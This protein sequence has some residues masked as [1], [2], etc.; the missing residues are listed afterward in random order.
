MPGVKIPDVKIEDYGERMDESSP[1]RHHPS[2]L[3]K[4]GYVYHSN[5]A[6]SEQ[7]IPL[8][9]PAIAMP[10]PKKVDHGQASKNEAGVQKIESNNTPNEEFS[11]RLN[12]TEEKKP[13]EKE[14][15]ETIPEPK[16]FVPLASC[17]EQLIGL[18]DDAERRVD[19]LRFGSFWF[20][21]IKILPD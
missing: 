11:A 1:K 15:E 4:D 10:G 13:R 17:S 12:S 2:T 19:Q 9:A 5:P 21:V 6:I 8:P 20:N 14:V 18:L 7:P 16:K 3:R